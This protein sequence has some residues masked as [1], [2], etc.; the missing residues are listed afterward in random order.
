M[1]QETQGDT[2]I[3]TRDQIR[4]LRKQ[5]GEIGLTDREIKKN[6]IELFGSWFADAVANEFIVE[7]NAM[8][9][10][11]IN[12]ANTN[13]VFPNSR[14][15][16]M[17]DISKDGI[18]FFT[19]YQSNKAKQ[20]AQN[21]R[22]SLLFPWY[23]MERQVIING[24]VEKISDSESADYF[25]TRPWGSQIGAWASQQSAALSSREELEKNWNTFAT[26]WPEGEKVPKPENWGGFLVTPTQIEFWQ[27]R[28]SRLHDRVKYEKV[29]NEWHHKRLNP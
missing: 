26:K 18:T 3:P 14:T 19:N 27:G 24:T 4:Q 13:E 22:V 8:V 17:K 1:T 2:P 9:L 25:A 7:A 28:Y 29:S 15:V 16:L 6:P 12:S 21:N 5:Y 20:I 23:A 11:T 10:S